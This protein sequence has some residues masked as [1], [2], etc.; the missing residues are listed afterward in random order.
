[1]RAD[2]AISKR[3]DLAAGAGQ[4]ELLRRAC[5]GYLTAPM[6]KPCTN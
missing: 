2:I 1:M 6:V 5:E 4:R 3:R